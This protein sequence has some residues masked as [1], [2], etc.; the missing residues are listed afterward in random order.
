MLV[1]MWAV[2]TAAQSPLVCGISPARDEVIVVSRSGRYTMVQQRYQSFDTPLAGGIIR[3]LSVWDRTNCKSNSVEIGGADF[4]D[5]SPDERYLVLR[6]SQRGPSMG[7]RCTY[8]YIYTANLST[9]LY[10]SP[11]C[12]SPGEGG[13]YAVGWQEDSRLLISVEGSG[14]TDAMPKSGYYNYKIDTHKSEF[15]GTELPPSALLD[16]PP[17]KPHEISP[18]RLYYLAIE[19]VSDGSQ[20][21]LWSTAASPYQRH[22]DIDY[23][24]VRFFG[25]SNDSRFAVLVAEDEPQPE[26]IIFNTFEGQQVQLPQICK[27]T[28]LPDCS[29]GKP[30]AISPTHD[31]LL[32]SGG[33][34]INLNT[35]VVVQIPTKHDFDR[36]SWSPDETYILTEWRPSPANGECGQFAI[37]TAGTIQLRYF[38]AS[39]WCG[40]HIAPDY[41]IQEWLMH[42]TLDFRDFNARWLHT[43]VVV[44][45]NEDTYVPY[46]IDPETG[47]R[48]RMLDLKG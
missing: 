25:W 16:L 6:K 15:I 23:A 19:P 31:I 40:E 28:S 36:A 26:I 10:D 3:S 33:W 48:T 2:P 32:T 30:I 24:S 18:N 46:L 43:Q 37:W 27:A 1:L 4:I 8:T 14:V 7:S 9:S 5:W 47:E 45:F 44:Y 41:V 11:M 35:F 12:S 17:N 34:L 21:G 22:F 42:L 29:V 13:V 39:A 20:I 38:H